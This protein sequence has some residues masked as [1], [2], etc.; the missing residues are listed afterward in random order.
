M[1]AESPLFI[2]D[3]VLVWAAALAAAIGLI[4]L[5]F[6]APSADEQRY[7]LEGT[8]IDV[9]GRKAIVQTNVTVVLGGAQIGEQLAI[10]VFWSDREFISLSKR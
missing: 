2:K 6:V 4:L 7:I 10:P 1:A 9:D 3:A 5:W 8:V